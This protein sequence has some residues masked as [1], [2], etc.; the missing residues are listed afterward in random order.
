MVPWW[1]GQDGAYFMY[2]DK[3]VYSFQVF[4]FLIIKNVEMLYVVLNLIAC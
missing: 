3:V 1:L 4:F 2:C